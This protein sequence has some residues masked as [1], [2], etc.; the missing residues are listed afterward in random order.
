MLG[1][2]A[3]TYVAMSHSASG[4][5]REYSEVHEA[6]ESEAG[7]STKTYRHGVPSLSLKHQ[8]NQE[9]SFPSTDDYERRMGPSAARRP[10]NSDTRLRKA[11]S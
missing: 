11:G 6:D 5:V 4:G 1:N 8:P 9:S 3:H 10:I 7:L 2:G